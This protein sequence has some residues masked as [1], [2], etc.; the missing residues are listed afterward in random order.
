MLGEEWAKLGDERNTP[1]LA[2]L[3]REEIPN[4]YGYNIATSHFAN[5]IYE[6]SV[7]GLCKGNL[8]E[9]HQYLFGSNKLG[10]GEFELYRLMAYRSRLF[11]RWTLDENHPLLHQLLQGSNTQNYAEF[12]QN[13]MGILDKVKNESE[14]AR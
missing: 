8:P 3:E 9:S 2:F 14:Q 7:H 11:Q 13:Y 4:V 6:E 5:I 1:G 12:R 10:R